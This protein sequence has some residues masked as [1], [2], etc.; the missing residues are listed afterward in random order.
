MKKYVKETILAVFS[1]LPSTFKLYVYRFFGAKIGKNVY[2]GF[3]SYFLMGA[4]NIKHLDIGDGCHIE[5]NVVISG[6]SAFSAGRSVRICRDTKIM[7]DAEFILGDNSFISMNNFI[8]VRSKVLIGKYV[9]IAP[10]CILLTHGEYLSDKFAI[11]NIKPLIINDYVWVCAGSILQPG[12]TINTESIV[13]AGA[14]VTSD[15][16]P[17]SFVAGVPAKII[18]SVDEIIKNN[19]S[20]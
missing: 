19:R 9:E 6:L 4:G 16:P 7:G 8:D 18:N 10:H 15:V 11:K 1:H 2:L 17:H 12:V 13:A 3:G 20:V 14:V 5:R